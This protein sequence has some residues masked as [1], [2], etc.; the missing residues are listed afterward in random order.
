MAD[1]LYVRI[2]RSRQ[3]ILDIKQNQVKIKSKSGKNDETFPESSKSNNKMQNNPGYESS[4]FEYI[5]GDIDDM[6]DKKVTCC[7]GFKKS[8]SKK[9]NEREKLG[10]ISV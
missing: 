4:I 8:K 2:W 1:D 6:E 3:K 10:N 9:N 5:E 7:Y